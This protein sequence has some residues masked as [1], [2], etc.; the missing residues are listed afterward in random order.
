MLGKHRKPAFGP[1]VLHSLAE[2]SVSE[3]LGEAIG[4][5][6]DGCEA[7]PVLQEVYGLCLP[8][9]EPGETP[10]I[11]TPPF[12]DALA[13]ISHHHA[14][15]V[16][17]GNDRVDKRLL[18]PVYVLVLVDYQVADADVRLGGPEVLCRET[19]H[20][21]ECE[22]LTA[23]EKVPVLLHLSSE[24]LVTVAPDLFYLEKFITHDA[25]RLEEFET[26]N[27][28]S[29][30]PLSGRLTE[31]KLPT[32]LKYEGYFLILVEDIV[33]AVTELGLQQPGGV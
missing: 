33:V 2:F 28:I 7:P 18:S 3:T 31:A 27:P 19:D 15:S 22:E 29:L 11:R 17:A 16:T 32:V 20:A 23:F 8:R 14:G 21:G 5:P 24:S 30:L 9:P 10:G 12:V 13:G 26:V 25:L 6:D 1:Q 4:S